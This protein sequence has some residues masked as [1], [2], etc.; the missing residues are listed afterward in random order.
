MKAFL[1]AAWAAV[2][3]V[4]SLPASAAQPEWDA[5]SVKVDYSDLDLTGAHGA[6]TLERRVASAVRQVCGGP[7][8]ELSE[9]MQQH[10]CERAARTA[11]SRDVENAITTAKQLP[12]TNSTETAAAGVVGKTISSSSQ[13][14]WNSRTR[15]P[16]R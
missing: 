7:T 2:L 13:Q 1:T 16:R 9:K 8:F 6:S 14:R 5:R 4:T 3:F 12:R 15:I 10:A 11:A